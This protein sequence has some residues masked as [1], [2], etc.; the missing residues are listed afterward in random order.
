MNR[1]GTYSGALTMMMNDESI[2]HHLVAM[3]LMATWHLH[4]VLEKKKGGGK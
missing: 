1:G 4:F 2:I 3:L